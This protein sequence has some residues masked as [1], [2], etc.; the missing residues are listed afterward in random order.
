MGNRIVPGPLDLRETRVVDVRPGDPHD[1][2]SGPVEPGKQVEQRLGEG[3]LLGQAPGADDVLRPQEEA[4]PAEVRN[5]LSH[6]PPVGSPS[7]LCR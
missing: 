7:L 2:V 1:R 6:F 5:C 3:E 4:E